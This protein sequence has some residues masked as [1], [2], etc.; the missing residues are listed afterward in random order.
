MVRSMLTKVPSSVFKTA[1][2]GFAE[3]GVEWL[4]LARAYVDAA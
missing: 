4:V 2:V 1:L 3:Q